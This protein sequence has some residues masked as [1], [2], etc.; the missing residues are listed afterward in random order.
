MVTERARTTS[1][2]GAAKTTSRDAYYSEAATWAVDREASE[3]KSRR[4]AWTIAGVAAGVAALQAVAIAMLLPLKTTVT[5]TLLVDR[6][7]GFVQPLRDLEPGVTQ[8]EALTQS[9]LVQYVI[10]RES[11]DLSTVSQDYRKVALWSADQA[12]AEYLGLMQAS[13]PDSPMVR[14]PRGTSLRT[15]VKSVSLTDAGTAMVRFE[16]RR[17]DPNGREAMVQHWVSMVYFRYS[18]APMKMED[19][20][21][22]P[23]GFQVLRYRR[24]AE[25]LPATEPS[26]TEPVTDAVPAEAEVTP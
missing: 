10:A 6:T 22:N 26:T 16:T 1:P 5:N 7:T 2:Q 23:L 21:V 20:F 25:A 3:R 4:L 14:Y 18:G 19:R 17:V 8:N 13:N 11:F 12:R 15:Q 24:D 9:F